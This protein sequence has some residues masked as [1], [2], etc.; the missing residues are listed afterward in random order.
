MNA[1]T[2]QNLIVFLAVALAGW[3]I[4]RR[5][6]RSATGKGCASGCGACRAKDCAMRKLEAQRTETTRPDE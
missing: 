2:I 6:L 5:C 4:F 1:M 3:F